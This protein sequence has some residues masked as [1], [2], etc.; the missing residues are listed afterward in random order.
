MAR[1][2]RRR[3]NIYRWCRSIE[4]HMQLCRCA[5][6]VVRLVRE[7][8]Q[9]AVYVLVHGSARYRSIDASESC[10]CNLPPP[11]TENNGY[12]ACRRLHPLE[13]IIELKT[14]PL[15]QASCRSRFNTSRAQ[16][17]VCQTYL[18]YMYMCCQPSH[19]FTFLSSIPSGSFLTESS[20][21]VNRAEQSKR[22]RSFEG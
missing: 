20:R 9:A 21:E 3:L 11:G 4:Q 15:G 5:F 7:A 6:G 10:Q 8:V 1:R 2:L 18:W 14:S 12:A 22:P 17:V 13:R 16:L 19:S